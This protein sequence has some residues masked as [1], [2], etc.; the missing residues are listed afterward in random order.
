[1]PRA[2]TILFGHRLRKTRPPER[3][4]SCECGRL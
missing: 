3:Q 4:S 2:V 1:M